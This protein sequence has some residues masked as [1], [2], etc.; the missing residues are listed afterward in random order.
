MKAILG[1]RGLYRFLSNFYKSPIIYRGDTYTT[2]E[3]LF[4]SFKTRD[5]HIRRII[6]EISLPED[7]KRF[8]RKIDL[9]DDWEDV[10]DN[11]MFITLKLKFSQNQ[12]LKKC[13]LNTGNRFLKESNYWHD[14]YWGDC[15]CPKCNPIQGRNQLGKTLMRVRKLLQ[16]RNDD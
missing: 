13:L 11:A 6:R 15:F 1:F 2:A 9:R 5:L 7:A 8:G 4:Q 3:H 10:K 16:E 14:N 12:K